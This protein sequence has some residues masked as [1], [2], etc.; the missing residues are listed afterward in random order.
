MNLLYII[1]VPEKEIKKA[2]MSNMV[3]LSEQVC[4]L[5]LKREWQKVWL[6]HTYSS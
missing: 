4:F 5:I 6:K 3:E 2:K 1:D